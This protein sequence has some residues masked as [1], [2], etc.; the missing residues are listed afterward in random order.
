MNRYRICA[1]IAVC[2]FGAALAGNAAEGGA[3]AALPSSI[4]GLAQ[5]K[6]YRSMRSSSAD[7]PGNA[8]ALHIEPGRTA[9]LADLEGPGEITHLWTTISTPDKLHLRNI[10]LRIFWDD[11]PF[12]SV[13]SPIGDFYGLGNAM[14]Y[15][16]SNPV[17]AIGTV[18]G[19]NA[20]WPMPFAKRA[21]VTVTNESDKAVG[22]FYYYVDWRK[23]D[24]PQPAA[25][26]F[27]AQYRQ[28]FP[29]E[30]GKPYLILDTGGSQG[31]FAGVSLTIHTQV[32]G[33]WGEGDDIFTIDGETTPSLWG[34]GSEDYFCGA[35]CY[36]DTF[37]RDYFGLPL[38][39]KPNHD[40]DNVWNVYRLHLESPIAFRR[41]LKLEI[42]HGAGGFDN[43][44]DGGNNDYS[45]VAYWYMAKPT[46]LK[47]ALPPAAQRM[48]V[49]IPPPPP[50]PLE[51][52]VFEATDMQVRAP[53]GTVCGAQDMSMWTTAEQG[54]VRGN[55]LWCHDNKVGE[56]VSVDFET[57]R[58]WRGELAFGLTKARDYG[59]ISIM[60]DGKVV[61]EDFNGYGEAVAPSEVRAGAVTLKPG[62]HTLAVKLLGRDERSSG[63]IW[64]M[65]YM[66]V[67]DPARLPPSRSS[68][69]RRN[70]GQPDQGV[71]NRRKHQCHDSHR[72]PLPCP[73]YSRLP[74]RHA[75]A[76]NPRCRRLTRTTSR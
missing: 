45:S 13:E 51:P 11:S 23:F 9:T 12:P 66:R 42:E 10:V 62:R 31:H 55:Q 7:R 69:R 29:C 75:A 47:G 25:G 67:A 21:R 33:W 57:T 60:L 59:R 27:H 68:S 39:K 35:W 65:D 15:Y 19:M 74:P 53:E 76:R 24:E 44:R 17:Q 40:A 58:P 63:T 73:H 46:P 30:D 16:F 34:T 8:D 54:W 32:A 70:K 5:L 50:P 6:D 20:F 38:R 14:Y 4:A 56:T 71:P 37:Y 26:Y 48:P 28:A 3:G 64:G 49:Y 18:N 2:A 43:T 72:R 36:G 22:A 1:L 52:G 41:S 61:V